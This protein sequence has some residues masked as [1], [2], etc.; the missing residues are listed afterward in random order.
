MNLPLFETPRSPLA[1][2]LQALAAEGVYFGTSSWKYEGWLGS[3]YTP[4]RYATRGRFSRK[5]FEAECLAEYAET[6]P[7]VC[8]DF[9]FYQFP[10]AETW[11][12]LFATAPPSLQFAFKAPEDLTVAQWPT[13][14]RYGARGGSDNEY[15]LNAELLERGFLGPLAAYRERVGVVILEFGAFPK[16]KYASGAHF[17]RDLDDFLRQLPSGWRF[18][19]EV[20]NPEFFEPGY[21]DILRAHNAAHVFNAWTRTPPIEAQ[22][23]LDHAYTADFLVAR[24]LLRQDRA[25]ADAVRKF[26][27]YAAIQEPNTGAREALKTLIQRARSQ[28]QMAFLFVN[29]RLEG[30]APGTI[31]AVVEDL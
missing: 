9:T 8:G 29:N 16:K 7:A 14:A 1:E 2:R 31:S 5:K 19:V 28:K 18:A 6:F 13:H 21:F 15:F 27:P 17:G 25:Y 4:E 20:R 22:V 12:R 11:Q 24:A 23:L 30:H 3:V 26:E 10:S